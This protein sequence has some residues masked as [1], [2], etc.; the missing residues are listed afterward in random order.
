MYI[1]VLKRW[2]DEGCKFVDIVTKNGK[3]IVA[4]SGVISDGTDGN[5]IALT[6]TPHEGL[7]AH[8][9]VRVIWDRCEDDLDAYFSAGINR[10]LYKRIE[11]LT[12]V[13][14]FD[15]LDILQEYAYTGFDDEN[16]SV[17]LL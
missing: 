16:V 6:V 4:K 5:M 2:Q 11:L 13:Q 12:G 15:L 7:M 17:D 10:K 3:F 8:S 1:Q 9:S 14:F